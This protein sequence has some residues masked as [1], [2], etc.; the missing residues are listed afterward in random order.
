MVIVF[1]TIWQEKGLR[2]IVFLPVSKW[3]IIIRAVQISSYIP[4]RIRLHSRKLIGN[5]EL[6]R[7][8]YAYIAS[9]KEIDKVDINVVTG[10]I[11]IVYR[12]DVLRMNTEL[13]RVEQYIMSHVERRG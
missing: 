5:A 8:V 4:G 1:F 11:L 6:G 7:K 9:Y 3:D 13:A 10:S 12:P 2:N